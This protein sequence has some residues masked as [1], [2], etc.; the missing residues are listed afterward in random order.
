PA[1]FHIKV[2]TE[3]LRL[4]KNMITASY[5]SADIK[6]LHEKAEVEGLTFMMECGLDPGIDHM[7]AM[8]V[9]NHIKEKGGQIYSFKSYC[10][11][12]IAPESDNNPWN[13][14]I[15]WNPRNVVLAGQGTA[16]YLEKNTYKY[17]PYH[18]LFSR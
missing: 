11:G 5:V 8:H 3:C 13:Y 6:A 17:I 10:G 18:Q 12:L 15:T 2:A 4:H 7:S 14:K 1:M 16:K 9:I